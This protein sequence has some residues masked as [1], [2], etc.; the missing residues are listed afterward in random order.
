MSVGG[1]RG[2]S[3]IINLK[4]SIS[5]FFSSIL[6]CNHLI[7][8]ARKISEQYQLHSLIISSLQVDEFQ[9]VFLVMH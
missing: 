1:E 4:L 6:N 8:S 9:E 3:S 7:H 2:T 5:S